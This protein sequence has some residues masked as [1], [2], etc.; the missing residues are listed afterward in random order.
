LTNKDVVVNSYKNKRAMIG[1]FAKYAV[2]RCSAGLAGLALPVGAILAGV[3]SKNASAQI[4][5]IASR[6]R[7]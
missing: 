3:Q 4:N 2:I 5:K 6:V 7:R 1:F